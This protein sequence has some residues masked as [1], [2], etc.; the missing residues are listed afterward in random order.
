MGV[1]LITI[2]K[3]QI[4]QLSMMMCTVNG[5]GYLGTSIYYMHGVTSLHIELENI[6]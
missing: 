2:P 6:L 1:I 3:F 5:E 4:N